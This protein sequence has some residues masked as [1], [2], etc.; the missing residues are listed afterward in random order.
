MFHI[1]ETMARCL[2]LK[3]EYGAELY[4]VCGAT[5]LCLQMHTGRRPRRTLMDITRIPA[6]QG[7]QER[8]GRLEI[9]AATPLTAVLA[10]ERVENWFPHLHA[11]IAT[12]GSPQIRNIAS[13]GGN[14][15][16]ASP[17]SDS[18]TPLLTLDASVRLQSSSGVREVALAEFFKGPGRSVLG[19]HELMVNVI[20]PKPSWVSDPRSTFHY[21]MFR[22]FG[23]RRA[24]IIATVNF[25]ARVEIRDGVVTAFSAAAGSVAPVP[26]VMKQL[27]AFFIGREATAS[28][29]DDNREEINRIIAA[30]ARPISDVRGSLEYKRLLVI[31]GVSQ[32]WRTLSVEY[33]GRQE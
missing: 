26:L 32:L 23:K 33:Q 18:A 3:A 12:I 19:E 5:D 4:P 20:I 9:G 29:Y 2:E 28:L 15:C 8:E 21:G 31:G 22:K 17:A 7:I 27:A 11:A 16:N 1:P 24:N 25:A 6:L 14:L 13:L 10:D 30:E